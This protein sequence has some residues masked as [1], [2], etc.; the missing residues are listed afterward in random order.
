MLAVHLLIAA[1]SHTPRRS[2]DL[3]RHKLT[4]PL[5]V[6]PAHRPRK[7]DAGDNVLVYKKTNS[8]LLNPSTGQRVRYGQRRSSTTSGRPKTLGFGAAA[9][10]AFVGFR[11]CQLLVRCF[12]R[13]KQL[14]PEEEEELLIQQALEQQ[15][16]QQLPPVVSLRRMWRRCRGVTRG[17]CLADHH[18]LQADAGERIA[19]AAPHVSAAVLPWMSAR[20][21]HLSKH[22]SWPG[23]TAR[24]PFHGNFVQ[25]LMLMMSLCAVLALP[26]A[27]VTVCSV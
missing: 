19:C 18:Q 10:T 3:H 27:A 17:V 7:Q 14:T 11:V 8:H 24:T 4:N 2:F 21:R 6:R 13:P 25:S 5:C 15:Q 1:C 9:I 12:R 23:L 26:C 16:M 20:A 22:R